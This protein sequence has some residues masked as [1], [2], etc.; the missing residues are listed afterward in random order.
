MFVPL[1][2]STV[3]FRTVTFDNPNPISS[4]GPKVG[5]YCFQLFPELCA[6]FITTYTDYR[7]MLD[8]GT[9]GDMS[10]GR[11]EKGKPTK[12]RFWHYMSFVFIPWKG[13]IHLY[14]CLK[15]KRNGANDDEKS[16]SS[17]I[18]S[19]S[20]RTIGVPI[21]SDYEKGNMS[22]RRSLSRMPSF[23]KPITR[24]V[25]PVDDTQSV[26]SGNLTLAKSPTWTTTEHSAFT[27]NHEKRPQIR[28]PSPVV[29][30]VNLWRPRLPPSLSHNPYL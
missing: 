25:T 6:M 5:F 27:P 23:V 21:E 3:A 15:K 11:R 28:V 22:F 2:R 24:P 30:D 1:F 8:T 10:R 13:P 16:D 12:S 7:G 14:K 18:S 26:W 29:S 9:W 4:I 20:G 17:S 19:S